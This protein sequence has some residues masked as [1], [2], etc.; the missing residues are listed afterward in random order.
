MRQGFVEHFENLNPKHV[1][2]KD[3]GHFEIED[4]YH[5]RVRILDRFKEQI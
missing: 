3:H 4:L 2:V 1:R 5:E